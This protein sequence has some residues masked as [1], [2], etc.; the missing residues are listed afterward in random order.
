[1]HFTLHGVECMG[2]KRTSAGVVSCLGCVVLNVR[3]RCGGEEVT[4]RGGAR[5][6][7]NKVMVGSVVP[8]EGRGSLVFHKEVFVI[9]VC[10][11]T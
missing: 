2:R 7:L 6:T 11:L 9:V 3:R 1:M 10:Q 4:N 5:E 8:S